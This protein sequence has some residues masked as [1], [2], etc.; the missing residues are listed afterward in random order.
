L[1]HANPGDVFDGLVRDVINRFVQTESA[2][3]R[4]STERHS[5]AEEVVAEHF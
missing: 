5:I 3:E 4:N 1:Q 2:T